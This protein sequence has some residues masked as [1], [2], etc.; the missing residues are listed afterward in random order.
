M[1]NQ[2]LERNAKKQEGWENVISPMRQR[3]LHEDKWLVLRACK[4]QKPNTKPSFCDSKPHAH[5]IISW[6]LSSVQRFITK[7]NVVTTTNSVSYYK[8]RIQC[9]MKF[10]I[11]QGNPSKISWATEYKSKLSPM[12][13]VLKC[14]I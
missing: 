12:W 10:K 2:R 3:G 13:W 8:S 7:C 4:W 11:T 9:Q 5:C 14:W 6:C 1:S